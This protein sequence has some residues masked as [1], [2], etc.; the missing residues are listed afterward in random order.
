LDGDGAG[1]E[2]AIKAYGVLLTVT[3]NATTVTLPTGRDPAEI[4]QTDGTSALASALQRTE[5][6]AKVVIDAHID[7]W[8]RQLDHVEGQL[9]AMRSA[10]SLIASTLPSE[11]AEQILQITGRQRMETLDED[12]HVIVRSELAVIARI[13]PSDTICQILR[14][15]ERLDTDHSEVTAEVAN[16]VTRQAEVPKHTAA[17]GDRNDSG[18]RQFSLA[19]GSSARFA[20]ASFPASPHAM[21]TMTTG[22]VPERPFRRFRS[23]S[24]VRRP[25]RH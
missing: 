5:P 20:V 11:T 6:L 10:A 24:S 25:M 17:A 8:A 4:L 14:V 3:R 15:V 7:R 23:E 16:A 9:N 12:L 13:L 21:A 1:R 18:G 22:P 2:A 19:E